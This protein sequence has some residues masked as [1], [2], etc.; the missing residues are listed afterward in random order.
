MTL[1]H[2]SCTILLDDAQSTSGNPTSRLY[3]NPI[4]HLTA[5]SADEVVQTLQTIQH[6]LAQKKYV[7]ANFSYELGEY[8]QGLKPAISSCP[9]IEAWIFDDVTK[10]SAAD[11]NSWIEA[12]LGSS[13]PPAGLFDIQE[14]VTAKDFEVTIKKIHELI[15]CGETYQVNYTYRIKGQLFGPPLSV[16]Q[17]LRSRQ[18]GPF[19]AFIKKSDGWVLSCS[20][21]WFLRKEGSRLIAKP[22]K[23]T[24][25]AGDMSPAF[26]QNDPK[27]RAE[28]LMIVDLLRNDL[29]KIS[30]PGTVKVPDLFQVQQH[31][32]V[33]QMTSTIEST[34][35]QDLG[36]L[37]LLQAIFPC[38]SITGTPKKKT[39]EIIQSLET[40]SRGLYCGSVAWFD[41]PS[42]HEI[43]GD[44]GMNVVIRTLTVDQDNH[45]LMGIG[46]GITIDSDPKEEWQECQTKANFLYQTKE[47]IGL[48]ETIR[49][50]NNTPQHLDLHLHRISTSAQKFGMIFNAMMASQVVENA[51]RYLDCDQ[52]YRMRLEL[53]AQNELSA[54]A[55]CIHEITSAQPLIWAT[56]ILGNHAR[57]QSSNVLLRHKVTLRKI[58]D[59]A[60]Q[61][62]EKRGGFDA[63]FVNELGYVTEGG[64][65]NVFIKKNNHWLTPPLSSGCLPGIMRSILL[66]DP[67]WSAIEENIT[68]DDVISS[69][70]IILTN[71]L[72]G[73][74]RITPN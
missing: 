25:K 7:V 27:N 51:C 70:E 6:Y 4:S 50:S 29:G 33:L 44:I 39:M 41:P 22:M 74:I 38:G 19:G 15:R 45:C 13:Q 36:L 48:F 1:G 57:M 17:A 73:I 43:L 59:L 18:P 20:P 42:G 60:W 11:V 53:N 5:N 32:D 46:A 40:E 65:S 12:Q 55:T 8:F 37:E 35:R 64:R 63:I 3:D 31:G 21:E 16:Y 34:A 47:H 28:N 54:N 14:T 9:W 69:D 72:R 58:Y 56:D 26:L 52:I 30:I 66:K 24:G 67:E 2:S 62:S 61:E 23:G 10:L 71:A 49:I 68:I